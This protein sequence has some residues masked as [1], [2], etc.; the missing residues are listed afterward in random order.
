[1]NRRKFLNYIGCG[2]CGFVINAGNYEGL[3]QI[4]LDLSNLS[5]NE[6]N[7]MGEKGFE[8]YV[9]NFTLK[10]CIDHLELIL[11]SN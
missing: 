1:M 6:R 7:C 4:I 2:C 11:K 9:E 3:A 5:A 10:N 8:Y